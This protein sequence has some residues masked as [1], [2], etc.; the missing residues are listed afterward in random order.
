V[1]FAARTARLRH[2]GGQ[3]AAQT[4]TADELAEQRQPGIGRQPFFRRFDLERKHRLCQIHHR[5]A[6]P[7]HPAGAR[8]DADSLP[9]SLYIPAFNRF[10]AVRITEFGDKATALQR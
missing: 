9:E 10:Y 4:H 2:L 6:S 7:V 5:L 3:P 8:T 1:K